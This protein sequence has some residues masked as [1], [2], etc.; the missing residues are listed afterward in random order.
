MGQPKWPKGNRADAA[1]VVDV[2]RQHLLEHFDFSLGVEVQTDKDLIKVLPCQF[3]K[4]PLVVTTF[5]VLAWAKCSACAGEDGGKRDVGSLDVVQAGRT[6]PRL[7]KDLT[8]TLVNPTFARAVCPVH[9][10]NEEHEMKLIHVNH[11]DQYG[12]YVLK[13]YEAG[14]SVYEQIAPGETVMFQCQRCLA[15]VQYSTSAVIR[16]KPMN[17]PRN[18][19][20]R[21]V[22]GY[23]QFVGIRDPESDPWA[24]YPPQVDEDDEPEPQEE[25]A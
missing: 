18:Q 7:A 20:S 16:F 9:P 5:Y 8:K 19:D 1:D 14:K 10:D 17:E 21:H 3:C 6:D 15:T 25:A 4:R 22:N 11:N 12:P 24:D 2:A 23:W 13:G